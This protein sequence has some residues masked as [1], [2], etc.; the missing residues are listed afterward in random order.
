MTEDDLTP[1]LG[2]LVIADLDFVIDEATIAESTETDGQR[3]WRVWVCTQERQLE[4]PP[5]GSFRWEPNIRGSVWPDAPSLSS[6]VGHTISVPEAYDKTREEYLFSM[7]VFEHSDV[8]ASR[9]RFVEGHGDVLRVEWHGR[10]DIHFNA[11]YGESVPFALLA[12]MHIRTA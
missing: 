11:T 5:L 8:S 1:Q 4:F 2:H 10:C 12:D 9:I 6:I 3:R 7:Y